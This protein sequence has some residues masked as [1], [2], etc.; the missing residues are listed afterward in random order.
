MSALP[1][2]PALGTAKAEG[3]GAVSAR[4]PPP[5]V[6]LE[7]SR[8]RTLHR[9]GK[10]GQKDRLPADVG[11]STGLGKDAK[12]RRAKERVIH[13]LRGQTCSR[14]SAYQ[15]PRGWVDAA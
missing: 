10:G 6:T 8:A 5:T 14:L 3:G 15:H 7:V 9:A 1:L 4:M 2:A 11:T 13:H 12:D